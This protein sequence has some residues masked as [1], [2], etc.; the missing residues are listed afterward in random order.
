MR[1]SRFTEEQIIRVLKQA[2][3]E[4]EPVASVLAEALKSQ[5]ATG[6]LHS[7]VVGCTL[8]VG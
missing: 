1:P 5:N 8:S 3:G 7:E 6:R 2:E 4:A